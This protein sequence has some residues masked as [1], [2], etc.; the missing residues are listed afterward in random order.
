MST[1]TTFKRIA[2]VAVAALG[3]GVISVAPSSAQPGTITVTATNGTAGAVG[4]ASDSV[5]GAQISLSGLLD[6]GYTDSVTVQFV[7]KSAYP[8]TAAVTPVLAFLD[9]TTPSLN[10]STQVYRASSLKTTYGLTDSITATGSY[11]VTGTSSAGTYVG[12]K[13]ALFL[14][15]A[16]STTRP[17]GTYAYTVIVK[18]YNS[19][20][21]STPVQTVTT[22]VNI[23]VSAAASV[24]TTPAAATSFS[25]LG[26]SAA[27]SADGVD[28]VL[29]A[30]ATIGT[31]AGYLTVGVR[32]A[33]GTNATVAQDSVT[34]TITGAGLL[35]Q[36]TTCGKSFVLAA[37]GD[38]SFTIKA[39]GTAGVGTITTKT[40][41]V[42]FSAKTVT[43]YAKAAK[44]ITAAVNNPVLAV[45]ANG[46]AIS[47]TAVDANG[48][49]W[50]GAMYI[51]AS[52]A[53]D[54]LVGGSA[55]TPVACSAYDTTD[56]VHYCPVTTIAAGTAKFK[57]I[58]AS[59][60]ALATATSNEVTVTVSAEKAAS[61]K[62]AFDK[63]SYAPFEKA[64]IT[65]TPVDA[66]GKAIAAQTLVALFA[67]GGITSTYAFSAGS[68]TLTASLISTSAL[69][70]AKS[71]TV[72]MPAASGDV[73]ITATGGTALSAAG[74]V[75]V[76]ATATIVNASVDAATDAANEATD[77]ANAATDAALAAADAADAATAAAQDASDAVAALS[78]SVS[79]LI[80]SLRAQI[81]SLTNLVI[82]I[83]KK[84]RA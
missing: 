79:K 37:T 6:A 18:S 40:N 82:K 17:A 53:A 81:T 57:L 43:F 60:V 33:T 83:Q 28:D 65:V 26:A 11:V 76:S 16:A 20:S 3:L 27:P 19:G 14:D 31:V 12:A 56:L 46:S 62:L 22:D 2:L 1:K 77:A 73:K 32:N 25:R 78:A 10:S 13:F 48:T 49:P 21:A 67:T 68:D 61:V 41:S 39:D 55:T 63:A 29:T 58:D 38:Q 80:S 50:T 15:S 74:Q 84:V 66:A 52:A 64:T 71:Y 24:S 51:V 72:Y 5:T 47:A 59:T 45:G 44:T 8:A 36:S 23:V 7:Q 4:A 75:A 70:G 54:A 9:S 42:T 30:V 34:A 35:C 69:T